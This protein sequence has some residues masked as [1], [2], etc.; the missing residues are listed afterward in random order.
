MTTPLAPGR[1]QRP[2]RHAAK[3][4][5]L[6]TAAFGS[7][8]LI[9]VTAAACG[10][11]AGSSTAPAGKTFSYCSEITTPPAEFYTTARLGRNELTIVPTGADID[12]GRAV[13]KRL[14]AA[15][16]FSNVP[17]ADLITSLR[18][19][20]CDAIISFMNNT[21]ERRRLVAFVD[22]LA[23]GQSLLLR[24][25]SPPI[26][27]VAGLSGKTVA[28]LHGTTEE[29]FL[30]D[31]NRHLNGRPPI[32][33]VSYPTDNE[34]IYALAQGKADAAFD[35]TPTVAYAAAHN[36]TLV[37]GVQLRSP[38]PI[39][40]ALRKGDPRIPKVEQAIKAIEADGTMQAIL[41]RWGLL[42]FALK[43]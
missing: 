26:A 8:L 20:K 1:G 11:P 7:G 33:I 27:D 13:A 31:A 9:A 43:P 21:A 41:S 6:R 42:R 18:A 29:L 28:V 37:E 2:R 40:I 30:Q 15:A 35:D 22:Y 3:P 32:N 16:S 12:I 4:A 14:G 34:A 17:F 19:K 36:K 23:A 10:S 25:G 38:I 24:K 39:G 5:V